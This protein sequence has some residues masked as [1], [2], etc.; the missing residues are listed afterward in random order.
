MEEDTGPA[1]AAAFNKRG[2]KG[3]TMVDLELMRKEGIGIGCVVDRYC[4]AL[5]AVGRQPQGI[6]KSSLCGRILGVC[7]N[8]GIFVLGEVLCVLCVRVCETGGFAFWSL[9]NERSEA[10]FI[11][12]IL[13]IKCYVG[14][15]SLFVYHLNKSYVGWAH[16]RLWRIPTSRVQG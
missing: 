8:Q 15:T 11:L 3:Y 7:S 13:L 4:Q 1:R 16:M 5:R 9:P 12:L 2:L 10:Y 14:G 6:P